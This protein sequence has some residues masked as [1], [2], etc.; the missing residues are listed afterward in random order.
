MVEQSLKAKFL[1][2]T[3]LAL[4]AAVLAAILAILPQRISRAETIPQFSI[5]VSPELPY[6]GDK[7]TVSV[8]PQNF[9]ATSTNFTWSR[10]GQKISAV[11]GIN[12]PTIIINTDSS[13][14]EIIN[15]GVEVDPGPGFEKANQNTVIYT[16]PTAAGQ[17]KVLSDLASNFSLESS[18]FNPQP[19][20]I[21]RVEAVTYTF[22][23]G[24]A[25]FQWKV[26]GKLQKESSGLGKYQ[27][28]FPSGREGE[29][30][31]VSVDVTTPSG[32]TR[33]KNITIR[34]AS[35]HVYWWA[36]TITPYWYKGKPLPSS[37]SRVTVMT[38]INNQTPASLNYAWQRDSSPVT[39]LSGFGKSTFAFTFDSRLEEEI[40]VTMRTADGLINKMAKAAVKPVSAEVGVY[41]IRPDSGVSFA[42]GISAFRGQSGTSHDFI[43]VP[44]YFPIE[45]L[46]DLGYEWSLNN[47]KITGEFSEPWL[48]T[49]KSD[50]GETYQNQVRVEVVD[51]RKNGERSSALLEVN[52]R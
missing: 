2:L 14:Q 12:R 25:S 8:T 47:R 41:E 31:T 40:S 28:L 9:A 46:G 45:S 17:E 1:W 36:D 10:D 49:L 6:A 27:L 38:L 7:V 20:D 3:G 52:L 5:S 15:L 29:P 33:S 30:Q 44:F 43:A 32:E 22:D 23:R 16:L 39:S 26:N 19:G 18:G 50:A 48:F 13:S 34:S 51:P 37:S 11:S 24:N 4:T 21:V 42:K 35:A